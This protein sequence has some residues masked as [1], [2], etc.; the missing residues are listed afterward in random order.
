MK[1]ILLVLGAVSAQDRLD[2]GDPNGAYA[3]LQQ[4]PAVDAADFYNRAYAAHAAGQGPDAIVNYLR[5][6][7]LGGEDE[8]LRFNLFLANASRSAKRNVAPPWPLDLPSPLPAR[9][10][11]EWLGFFA[12]VIGGFALRRR[13]HGQP[14]YRLAI[15]ALVLCGLSAAAQLSLAADRRAVATQPQAL[16]VEPDADAESLAT[17]ERGQVLGVI[18]RNGPWVHVMQGDGF[19]G[20]VEADSLLHVVAER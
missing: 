6:E 14:A 17:L 18:D 5:A 15:T 11:L 2:A 4:E 1:F 3:L 10:P 12:F 13:F 16:R 19:A 20:W 9:L 8:S 7:R